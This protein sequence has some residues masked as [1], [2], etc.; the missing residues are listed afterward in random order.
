MINPRR[1]RPVAI[2]A[3]LLLA[4]FITY[5][6]V[7]AGHRTNGSFPV[8]PTPSRLRLT[9]PAPPFDLGRLG[10]GAP[11]RFAGHAKEPVVVNF[12]ASWCTDC[13]AELDAFSSVSRHAGSVRFLGVD[14][15]DSATA[16]AVG[17]LRKAG[18]SYPVGIDQSG[19]TAGRYLVA[20]L[21]VTFFIGANGSVHGEIFGAASASQLRSWV[22][23]LEGRR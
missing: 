10:G 4:G 5:A 17:L 18:I 13:V 8:V 3:C 6:V 7:S 1:Y 19:T 11:V 23:R 12:F 15:N 22:Q 14:T 2:A 16:T 9:A 21:P 20:A